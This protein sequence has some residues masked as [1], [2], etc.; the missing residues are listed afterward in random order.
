[1]YRKTLCFLISAPYFIDC[2]SEQDLDEM[3]IEIIRNTLYK[4]SKSKLL[5]ITLIKQILKNYYWILNWDPLYKESIRLITSIMVVGEGLYWAK[6]ITLKSK[7]FSSVLVLEL[8]DYYLKL[9]NCQ[10]YLE[11]F[12]KF[13]EDQGGPTADVMCE[14]LAVSCWKHIKILN[15]EVKIYIFIVLWT[16]Q[17]IKEKSWYIFAVYISYLWLFYNT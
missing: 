1:M 11:D 2:I 15:R 17:I 3:N 8:F 12:Y 5:W 16:C 10:A 9:C 7:T 4:V 6:C 14:A 13:C